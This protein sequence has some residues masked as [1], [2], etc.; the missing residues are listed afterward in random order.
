M[1]STRQA[2][3]SLR[4]IVV[5]TYPEHDEYAIQRGLFAYAGDC[6]VHSAWKRE[7]LLKLR[8]AIDV[9][10]SEC[11]H[12]GK[13]YPDM[14]DRRMRREAGQKIA[15]AGEM[16]QP[17]SCGVCGAYLCDECAATGDHESQHFVPTGAACGYCGAIEGNAKYAAVH[18]MSHH[19]DK[20][21]DRGVW[22]V[23][24]D[25]ARKTFVAVPW[26]YY[27]LKGNGS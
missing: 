14:I 13:P 8:A 1:A 12:C 22:M 24:T 3:R 11:V 20:L 9:A 25:H 10:L 27:L 23:H 2:P 16:D 21:P 26:D 17:E 19:A 4:V 15:G 6:S 18:I 5:P 7:T